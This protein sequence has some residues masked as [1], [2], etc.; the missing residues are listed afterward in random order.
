MCNKIQACLNRIIRLN[1]FTGDLAIFFRWRSWRLVSNGDGGVR[2]FFT[3]AAEPFYTW[4]PGRCCCGAHLR[5]FTW[6]TCLN[7][8]IIINKFFFSRCSS[9]ATA[10][11]KGKTSEKNKMC[12]FS[13]EKPV[14]SSLRQL[15]PLNAFSIYP[16]LS[17][18]E[19]MSVNSTN[20]Y[21]CIPRKSSWTLRFIVN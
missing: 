20:F 12:G 11:I 10:K 5:V 17:I 16:I 3:E 13:R 2:M 6:K 15:K 9:M 21:V 1:I 14:F 8:Y 19:H 4:I 7:M 18:T